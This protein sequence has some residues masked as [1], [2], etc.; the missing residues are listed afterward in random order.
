MKSQT[1]SSLLDTLENVPLYI[2]TKACY[3]N[4]SSFKCKL[5][6]VFNSTELGHILKM[7]NA[8]KDVGIQSKSEQIRGQKSSLKIT[9]PTEKELL[10]VGSSLSS[11]YTRAYSTQQLA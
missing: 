10:W 8:T 5:P 1:F 4:G 6:F 7:E 3:T 2:A 9:L 11:K